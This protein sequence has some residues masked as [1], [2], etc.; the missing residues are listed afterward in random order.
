[1]LNGQDSAALPDSSGGGPPVQIGRYRL[2]ERLGAGGMG[3]V[4]KAQDPQLDRIVALKLPRFE[5]PPQAVAQRRQRFQREG[6]AAA[7]IW[8]PHVCPI[9][10][11]G[12][13]EGHPYVVMA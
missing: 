4:Y 12:E 1:M 7:R 2:L 9:Y 6:R 13:W 3:T 5:G 11:V 8:H 10:D